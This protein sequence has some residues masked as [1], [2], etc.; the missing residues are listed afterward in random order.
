MS[1][2]WF[3]RHGESEANA[4]KATESSE[5]MELTS[6]GYEQADR[7][8][9]AIEKEPELIITSKFTRAFQTAQAT[10]K[11]FPNS[12]VE[13]WEI[14]EFTYL[15]PAGL[16]NTTTVQRRPFS[17]AYWARCDPQFIH[18]EGAE[19]FEYFIKRVQ[20]MQ[21]RIVSIRD[22]FITVFSHGFVIKALLWANLTGTFEVTPEYMRKF[23]LFHQTFDFPNCGIIKAEYRIN[24]KLFSG[25]I[26][27]H[28]N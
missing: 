22:G 24:S 5:K 27:D 4:G 3:I 6:L 18:G 7:V 20:T 9:L 28:L 11:R 25:I 16:K 13:T 10:I 1:P 8:S 12:P 23:Y 17:Q 19:S 21:D 2:V 14:Q 15:S 26:K